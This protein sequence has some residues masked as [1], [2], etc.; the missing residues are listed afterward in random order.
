M[1]WGINMFSDMMRYLPCDSC[2]NG[3]LYY[4]QRE[5]MDAWQQPEVFRLDDIDKLRDGIISD[6]LVL[7][8]NQCDAQVRFTFKELEKKF[9]KQLS[10]RILT[11]ISKNDAPDPGSFRKTD[12]IYVYCGKCTG[13]D[14]KGS[15]PTYIHN[16][17]T[18]KRLPHGF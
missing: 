13:Y 3:R 15:C 5:T 8:C 18:L 7:I 11:M 14:G 10:N 17:C 9:R 1:F 4:S 16:N 12:R 6:I 2:E